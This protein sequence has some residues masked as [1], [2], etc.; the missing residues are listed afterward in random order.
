MMLSDHIYDFEIIV[1]DGNLSFGVCDGFA[2]YNTG[3]YAIAL[4]QP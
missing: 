1:P 2:S 3:N 4:C